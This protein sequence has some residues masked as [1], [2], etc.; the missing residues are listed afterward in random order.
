ML[1]S[2]RGKKIIKRKLMLLNMQLQARYYGR[3]FEYIH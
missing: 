1:K 2:G 3:Y